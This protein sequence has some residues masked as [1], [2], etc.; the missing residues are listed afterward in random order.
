MELHKMRRKE[1]RRE[2][3]RKSYEVKGRHEGVGGRKRTEREEDHYSEYT[4]LKEANT[5]P[6][7]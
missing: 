6:V 2:M 4:R 5:A 1:E 3:V 7:T